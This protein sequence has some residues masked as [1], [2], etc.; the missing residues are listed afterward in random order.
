MKTK[1]LQAFLAV[2]HCELSVSIS[3]GAKRNGNGH[4]FEFHIK[5][6]YTDPGCYV[7]VEYWRQIY[8]IKVYGRAA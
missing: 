7:S 6:F 5:P 4:T 3:V 1:Y 2:V 8:A